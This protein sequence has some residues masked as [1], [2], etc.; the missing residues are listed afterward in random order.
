MAA[1]VGDPIEHSLSPVL[2]RAAHRALGLDGWTYQRHRV[3]AGELGSF[4]AARDEQW[5]GF[6]VTAPLKE[7]AL[8]LAED[9]GAEAALTGA[10]NTLVRRDGHWRAENTDVA[11]LVAALTEIGAPD[12]LAAAEG[13]RVALLGSGATARSALV[14]LHHLGVRAVTCIVR[15]RMRPA[16]AALADRL[17]ME[18]REVRAEY[19]G[20][21]P[22]PTLLVS[23]LPAGAALDQRLVPRLDGALVFDVGYAPWPSTLATAASAAG[24]AAVHGGLLM[25]LHQA[26]TQVELMTGRPAPVPAMQRAL[27][28]TAG[29]F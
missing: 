7:E 17:G 6:S 22:T 3:R 29:G 24:A 10:A 5:V 11:G 21:L 1:V 2:H 15:D 9:A 14:A 27:A 19:A 23:T 18:L 25:L 8:A 20:S 26:A 16:T 28:A 12:V 13:G 4:V